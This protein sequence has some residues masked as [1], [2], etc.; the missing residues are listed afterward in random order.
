MQRI[1]FNAAELAGDKT[2][3][4]DQWIERL[5]SGYVRLD[6][7]P[8]GDAPFRGELR[9][10]AL[11]RTAVGTIHGTVNKIQRSAREIAL[12]DTDNLVLLCNAGKGPMRVAQ[13]GAAVDLDEG[14]SVLIEQSLPSQVITP[15][16]NCHLLAL[17]APRS[18]L[19]MRLVTAESHLRT[20]IAGNSSALALAKAYA[21]ILLQQD[22]DSLETIEPYVSDHIADLIALAITPERAEATEASVRTVRLR[23]VKHDI[24][25]HID[26]PSFTVSDVAARQGISSAYVHKLLAA[27]G[28]SFSDFVLA[29]R[30]SRAHRLLR[31]PL[32]AYRQISTIAF[33]V[34]FHDLSYFNRTFWRCFG[35]T[36]S[37]LRE[38]IVKDV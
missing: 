15:R 10:A 19:R 17:Q 34:G 16:G 7:D 36:P 18:W 2:R 11:E 20:P 38:G 1:I 33:E 23:A 31:D 22:S 6:A 26:S 9:I 8:A 30:L 37:D 28:T 24:L 21:N 14:A 12:E 27:S 13:K 4:K 35:V 25:K 5:S 3:R 32:L 29:E